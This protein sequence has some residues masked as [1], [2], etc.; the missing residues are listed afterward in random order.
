SNLARRAFRR[1]VTSEDTKPLLAFYRSGREEG[2]FDHG[3]ELAL[4]AMLVSP[5]FLFR[6]ELDPRGA[7]PGQVYRL[8]D[9]ELASRLSFFLWSSIP[10][11][12][13]LKFAEQSKLKDPAVLELQ[14]RRL[15]DDPRSDALANN[16]GGQWLYLR[17]LAS[18]KPD[19][20][21]FPEF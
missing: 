12:E 1:P 17:N 14:V 2:D 18:V 3:I 11:E 20:D 16:F 15:L 5:D 10:D 7:S 21:A 8:T 19:A 6:V 13:L 9:Y 4:G